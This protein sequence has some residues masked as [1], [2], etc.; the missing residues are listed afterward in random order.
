MPKTQYNVLLSVI[1]SQNNLRNSESS[2][3]PENYR[4][5]FIK[6]IGKFYIAICLNNLSLK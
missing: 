3:C 2:Q 1:S 4:D 6:A 5:N